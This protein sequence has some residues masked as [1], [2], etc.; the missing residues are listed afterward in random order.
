[1]ARPIYVIGHKNSDLDSV[2]SAYAYARLLQLQGEEQ[3]IAARNGELKPEVRF[4]LERYNVEA[5]EALEDVY[6]QVRDVMKRGVISAN[7]DQPLLEAGQLLQEHNRRSMPVVDT[8]NKVLGIIATED[9][10]KLFFNDLDPQSVNR[11]PLQMDNLVRAL[12]G[13]VLVEGRRKLGNRVIVGAMQ[14]ETMIDYV[15]QGCLVVLGDREDAQLAAIESGAAALVITG[16][17]LVSERTLAAARKYGVL[18]ISTGHHTFTAVRL[19]NLSISV[20][21]IM[22]REFAFCH[23][24][25]QMSEVQTILARRRSLP[26][27]NNDGKLV[28]YLSRTDLI[29]AR[30]KRVILVDHNEQSQAV[31]GIEEAELLGIIDHH[32]IADVHTNK[33]IMFRADPVGCTGTIIAGLYHEAGIAIP[34]EVAGLLLAG[35]LYDTLILQSPTCTTRDERVAAELAE[36][37]GEQIE[38]YGQEVFAAAAANLSERT[39]RE[40]LTADFKEFAVRDTKFAI[41]TVET[42]S[43]LTIE[44]RS[45]ELLQTMQQLTQERGY[46]SFLFMI[47][48]IINMRSHVLIYGGEHAVAEI[49]GAPLEQDGH[50]VVAEN[51]V[52]RK[53]QLVPLLSRIQAAL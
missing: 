27:V 41:G 12:K 31:D 43:P 3:A 34:H 14:A 6:L 19:I 36:I 39:A 37:A 52:S 44:K 46:S 11:V 2:A 38:Q 10:A 48:D 5:P 20:Q 40:L 18:V 49:L 16:D 25:D 7:L 51:L 32:R 35:L 1:M 30:P 47:V 53:K 42:A 50:S 28:G 13:R 17:L 26:V 45:P 15:E 33:P 9:F 22:N 8:E 21:H 24:E 23:P 4:V 29:N